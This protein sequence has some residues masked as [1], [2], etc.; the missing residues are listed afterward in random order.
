MEPPNNGQVGDKHFIRSEVPPSLEVEMYGQY[1]R[2]G[3]NSLSI[4]ERLSTQWNLQSCFVRCSEVLLWR[5]IEMYG[6]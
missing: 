4:V 3:S 5:Y 6:Q 2:H 1:N